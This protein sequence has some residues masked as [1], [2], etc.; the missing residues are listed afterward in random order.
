MEA[1][2]TQ[3]AQYDTDSTQQRTGPVVGCKREVIARE[4]PARKTSKTTIV[5]S[6]KPVV[7]V[8]GDLRLAETMQMHTAG[9]KSSFKSVPS[10]EWPG[11]LQLLRTRAQL[12]HMIDWPLVRPQAPLTLQKL[13]PFPQT[14]TETV[15]ALLLDQ[16]V[17]V[18]LAFSS[19]PCSIKFMAAGDETTRATR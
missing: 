3:H 16:R 14:G 13:P 18:W 8:L 5:T 15:Q 9:W 19:N 12:S 10:N 7:S 4:K 11:D 2:L 6:H 17:G 1:V